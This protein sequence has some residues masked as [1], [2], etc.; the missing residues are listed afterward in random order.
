MRLRK[1]RIIN[2]RGY[3]D[4]EIDIHKNINVIIG[5]NDVGKSTI[6]DAMNIFF[7]DEVKPE[8]SDCKIDSED[9]EFEI[10]CCFEIDD[11]EL[12][13]L[14]ASNPTTLKDEYL[15]NKEGL[16]EVRKSYNASGKSITK[17]SLS[18]SIN[19]YYPVIEEDALITFKVTK[20]KKV[21]EKYKKD[22]PNYE[23]INKTKKADMRIALFKKMV[24]EDTEFK[25]EY[26]DI[27]KIEDENLKTWEKLKK[28][29]PLFT[30]FQSDRTNTD[31]DKEVQDP[32]KAI[33]K[34]VLADMEPEL[35][36]IED[37]VVEKVEEIGKDTIEKLKDFDEDIA[38]KLKTIPD[39]KNWDTMFR[40]N[41]DTDDDI[42]LNKRGSGIR[43]LI[44]LSYFRAQAEKDANELG[45][46]DII[47]AIEEPETSQH[48]DYQTMIIESLTKISEKFNH[49]IILTTHTPEIVKMVEKESVILVKKD[50]L[51]IP[52]V[53]TNEDIRHKEIIDTLGILPTINAKVVIC[54]EGKYDI[55]F[56]KTINNV[57]SDFRD[58]VDLNSDD[59]RILK[60]EEIN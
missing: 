50:K 45:K 24:T 57:V 58:I 51:N 27:K 35:K 11:E 52:Y 41:L 21:L 9:M 39:L 48:P 13:V 25:E 37:K 4:E 6:I 42:P 59:I 49:Q 12:I 5:K 20:L 32:M 34:K 53:T 31:E 28:E 7:N 54:V 1:I 15:L 29:L 56:L 38:T 40:F 10:I 60:L 33:T 46:K 19:S 16:L 47:Y 26:I 44:L 55:C 30:L 18:V 14:D 3:S 2:F 17:G 8:I 23:D 43:R 36:E 22:I